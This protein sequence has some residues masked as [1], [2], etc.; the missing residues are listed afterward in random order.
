[1]RKTWPLEVRLPLSIEGPP[2]STRF[3]VAEVTSGTMKFVRSPL[4]MLKEFQSMTARSVCWW[5]VVN[6]GTMFWICASPMTTTPP[7]GFAEL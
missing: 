3:S 2:F 6:P 1:M 4:L 7:V 5:M